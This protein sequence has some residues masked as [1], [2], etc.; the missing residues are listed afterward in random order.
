LFPYNISLKK[1]IT[2]YLG[3]WSFWI[4]IHSLVLH[5]LGWNWEMSFVDA[6]VSI[7]LLAL[8]GFVTENTYR[9]YKPGAGN[10]LQH[11]GY[12][13]ALTI[14]YMLCFK[15]IMA[16][17]YA[18]NV[19]YLQ[20][21]EISLPLRFTFALLMIALMTVTSWL[22]HFMKEEEESKRRKFEAEKLLKESELHSLQ[23]Q[24]QPHFLFNSLNSISA[25]AGTQPEAARKMIQ[26]LSDFLRGTLKKEEQKVVKLSEELQH[27]NL[28]LEIEKVRFG[29]RLNTSIQVDAT[30]LDSQLPSLLLQPLVENAI[31]F[32]LYDT[33]EEITIG[34]LCAFENNNLRIQITNPFDATT[35]VPKKGV[36]FG[37]SAVNRR[38]YLIYARH[39]LLLIEQKG[40][41]FSCTLIIPQV[42]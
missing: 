8:A 25:L 30:T 5:R 12:S 27:L 29:N 1:A 40:N 34:I 7:L 2:G 37:L 42:T 18:E 20:F 13:I 39:D 15:W 41:L 32:G 24:L 9:F 26:Q 22:F 17:L 11:L 3:W 38:L 28:Y 19:A 23:Q 33:L 4:L 14:A 31:K 10:R 21:L 16:N 36:G 6:L 35:A